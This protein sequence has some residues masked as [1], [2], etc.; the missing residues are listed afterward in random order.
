MNFIYAIYQDFHLIFK[1]GLN[2]V[3]IKRRN[4]F[5]IKA[6]KGKFISYKDLKELY[7]IILIILKFGLNIVILPK[8]KRHF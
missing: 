6:I 2:M 8:L 4:N 1:L 5:K 7:N 3:I